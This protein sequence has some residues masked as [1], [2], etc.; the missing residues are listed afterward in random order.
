MQPQSREEAVK[1]ASFL[2]AAHAKNRVIGHAGTI[3]WHSR[4]DFRHFRQTTMGLA[5]VMG[6]KT[7]ESLPGPLPG[8]TTI[9][10][11]RDPQSHA[12]CPAFQSIDQAVD[13]VLEGTNASAIAF[14]GGAAIYKE[15]LSLSWMQKAW[16]TTIDA[17]P[18]GDTFLPELSS[19]W[20][21]GE[22]NHLPQLDGEPAASTCLWQR[23]EI[24]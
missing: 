2:I 3:P 8:R 10:I 12:G 4:A 19:D 13:F 14:A 17:E 7:W 20:R 23:Q 15:A 11:T 24:S 18:A 6:R 16:L 9:V 21:P 5:L 1:S 22:L